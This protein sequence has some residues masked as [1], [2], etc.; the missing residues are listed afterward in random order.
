[1]SPIRFSASYSTVSFAVFCAAFRKTFKASEK[2]RFAYALSQNRDKAHIRRYF[3][4]V[5]PK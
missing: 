3:I 5:V 4:D 1:M 2:Y